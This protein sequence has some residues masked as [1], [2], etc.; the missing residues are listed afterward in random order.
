[1]ARICIHKRDFDPSPDNLTYVVKS[2]IDCPSVWKYVVDH[3]HELSTEELQD[4][5]LER[6]QTADNKLLQIRKYGEEYAFFGD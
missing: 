3:S 4:L 2:F 6:Q 5:P 1:M